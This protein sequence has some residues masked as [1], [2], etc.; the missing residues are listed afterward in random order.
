VNANDLREGPYL[1]PFGVDVMGFD[2]GGHDEAEGEGGDATDL[3]ITLGCALEQ[4]GLLFYLGHVI[5][6]L[7]LEVF[8][9][10]W[11][12]D[13][14]DVRLQGVLELVDDLLQELL[15]CGAMD[16]FP[17]VSGDE[18]EDGLCPIHVVRVLALDTC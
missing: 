10:G 13:G 9:L 8:D 17:C 5:R 12:L 16:T 15:F 6:I 1:E 14:R 3:T 2:A 11:V 18:T 4:L 7:D